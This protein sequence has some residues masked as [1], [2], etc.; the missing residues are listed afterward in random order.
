MSEQDNSSH[1][2]LGCY[3]VG[4]LFIL[5]PLGYLALD[6]HG[7]FFNYLFWAFAVVDLLGFWFVKTLSNR[8]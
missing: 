2:I 1:V 8:I 4:S 5:G 3:I 7:S 6:K